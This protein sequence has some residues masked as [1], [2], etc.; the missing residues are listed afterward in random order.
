[1]S[2]QE[3]LVAILDPSLTLPIA[4]YG[5]ESGEPSYELLVWESADIPKPTE[6]E[7]AEAV[8]Q[9]R[10]M[11]YR[12]ARR[13]AYPPI[14]EQLD[15]IFHGGVDLWREKIQAVKDEFPKE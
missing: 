1:M 3:H 6:E 12:T 11:S 9:A 4:I 14:A 10:A 5:D 8:A 2:W 15:M 7:F 13:N